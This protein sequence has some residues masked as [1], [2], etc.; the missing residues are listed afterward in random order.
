M[1]KLGGMLG[2]S[3]GKKSLNYGADLD[4]GA[5]LFFIIFGKFF[6]G[7]TQMWM[8][9]NQAY[10][11][12]NTLS[13]GAIW[14][15]FGRGSRKYKNTIV[16]PHQC[17]KCHQMPAQIPRRSCTYKI[18]KCWSSRDCR[19]H[20]HI[21]PHLEEKRWKFDNAAWGECGPV[22]VC[23]CKAVYLDRSCCPGWGWSRG[24]RSRNK[25]RGCWRTA[26]GSSRSG[27]HQYLIK[28]KEINRLWSWRLCRSVYSDVIQNLG[29]FH[30]SL[31]FVD[32]YVML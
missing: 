25:I 12:H 7:N 17:K 31:L 16:T 11:S 13:R 4:P 22:C 27:I 28:T 1:T 6:K 10:L 3:P 14:S 21:H 30:Q 19:V 18:R 29:K 9:K 26:V 2:H 32:R 20:L 24:Y 15:R 23:V 8:E 5:D